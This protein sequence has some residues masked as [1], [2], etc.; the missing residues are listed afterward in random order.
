MPARPKDKSPA[1]PRVGG[2]RE[3]ARDPVSLVVA[4]GLTALAAGGIVAVF[5]APLMALVGR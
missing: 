2:V 3:P 1:D 4:L 5:S